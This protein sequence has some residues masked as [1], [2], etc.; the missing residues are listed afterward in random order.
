MHEFAFSDLGRVLWGTTVKLALA[1]GFAAG[2]VWTVLVSFG[3]T[4][5]PIEAILIWPILW[6]V[7]AIPLSLTIYVVALAVGSIVPLLGTFLTF[8]GSL[9]VCA[10]D[11][12]VYTL[13]RHA[14]YILNVA[15]LGFFNLRPV[16]FVTYPD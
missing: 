14:P 1:R 13:N 6:S 10:G 2:I 11:P 4:P 12:L 8:F 15:D 16:V 3:P 5:V 9:F 7:C